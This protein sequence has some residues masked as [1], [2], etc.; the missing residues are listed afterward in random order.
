MKKPRMLNYEY[1]EDN[2]TLIP[3]PVAPNQNSQLGID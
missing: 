3:D 2:L 1:A